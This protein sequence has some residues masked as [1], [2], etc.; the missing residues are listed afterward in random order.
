[1]KT[2]ISGSCKRRAKSNLGHQIVAARGPNE[3]RANDSSAEYSW[4]QPAAISEQRRHL[5]LWWDE[6]GERKHEKRKSTALHQHNCNNNGLVC[7]EREGFLHNTHTL[8]ALSLIS[9]LFAVSARQMW[10]HNT[11]GVI[12][13]LCII[14]GSVKRDEDAETWLLAIEGKK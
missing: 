3:E 14:K 5:G 8:Y 7:L 2:H 4:L 9:C 10:K 6:R 12:K 13:Y 1:M 11:Q